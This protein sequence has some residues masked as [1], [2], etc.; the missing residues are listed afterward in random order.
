M[1][2]D[3]TFS[4]RVPEELDTLVTPGVRVRVR[5]AGR[6]LVG[7]VVATTDRPPEGVQPERIQPLLDCYDRFPV[8]TPALLA[9]AEAAARRALVAWGEMLAPA[10]PPA[11]VS[12]AARR[13]R[14]ALRPPPA[15]PPALLG[16]VWRRVHTL[17]RDR[18]WRRPGTLGRHDEA[19]HGILLRLAAGGWIE[20]RDEWDAQAGTGPTGLL[21]RPAGEDAAE[22][23][24]R[25]PAQRRAVAYLR[26]HG[27]GERPLPVA[28]LLAGASVSAGVLRELEAKGLVERVLLQRPAP[29][30]RAELRG[31]AGTF[32]LTDEQRRCLD[33][34]ERDLGSA[35]APA[36]I[37]LH[38][39]TGSGK[40]EVYL[41]GAA[42]ALQRGL[43]A[44][45]LVPEI[46][47]TPQL[48]GRARAVLGEGV[49]VLHSAMSAGDRER[50]WW[51]ARTGRA[52]VVVGPR[53]A[54][55]APLERLGLVVVDEEQDAAYKQEERPRY[56]GRQLAIWR[57]HLE[58]AVLVLGSATPSVET[59]E[60]ARRGAYRLERIRRRVG[61]R[62]LPRVELV[63][64]REEWRR[65]G[66][67]LLSRAL[68][69]HIAQRL[70]TG[71]QV[72]VLLNRRGYATAVLCRACGARSECPDCAVT[73]TLHRADDSLRCHYC[74]Y[75]TRRP[76]AC[77]LCGAD[78]LHDLGHG[79]ERLER[80]LRRRYPSAR[81]GRFDADQTRRRG[82]HE[83]ILSAFARGEID[84]LVGTQ[85]LAKGHDFP[86]VTLVGV[87]GADAALGMPDFR[88]AERTFQLL[89]QM[90]GRA[91]RG[92]I[93]GEVLLQAHD[94]S[95]YAIRAALEHD[96]AA[97]YEQ[98]I[99]YRR[100]MGYPPFV[101]LAACV[102]RGKLAGVVREEADRLAAAL[103]AHGARRVQVLGPATPPLAR[104]R[105]RYRMQ[106]LVK[107]A[108]VDALVESLRAAIAELRRRRAAPRDLIV[109]VDPRTLV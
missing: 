24:A 79:T 68:E 62:P 87:V 86:G 97:F 52:R 14:A 36:P 94:P 40:T 8:V 67:R 83:R 44:L 30:L 74:G 18:R 50:A 76:R 49:A 57:A 51:R 106:V 90:A 60:R 41:R 3:G 27:A 20:W 99:A 2:A 48:A 108:E 89:T 26:A 42:A 77:P 9:L 11:G 103:R 35:A 5:F 21:L 38:G 23:L 56:D 92:A 96:Y 19:L 81:I 13:W 91:G 54:V 1:P 82:A 39:V 63:D 55:F 16:D 6:R 95:H 107:A 46:G 43:S 78:A 37:L 105:G 102:C 33:A 10:L 75:R 58:G 104:L 85:M 12:D 71:E 45:L 4:Y 100:R 31:G 109:D 53:S 22:A 61:D 73:L 88:A 80:A 59:Y 64:M 15:Q 70:A 93:A 47:L 65:E 32:L 34:I 101:H 98:E 17:G 29:P 72:L 69:E 84:L 28:E 25:A 7:V 66:R